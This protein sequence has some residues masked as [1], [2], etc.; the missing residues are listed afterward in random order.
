MVA[1]DVVPEATGSAVAVTGRAGVSPKRL[2]AQGSSQADVETAEVATDMPLWS[3]GGRV[4][5]VVCGRGRRTGS[6][7]I[8]DFGT[9]PH[10]S[11]LFVVGGTTIEGISKNSQAGHKLLL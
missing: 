1:P 7:N 4:N 2:G 9:A 11:W 6:Q 8:L 3:A 10:T 5:A